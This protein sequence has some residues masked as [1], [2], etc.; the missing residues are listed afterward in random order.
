MLWVT[1]A[2]HLSPE[3]LVLI[4]VHTTWTITHSAKMYFSIFSRG[5]GKEIEWPIA[6]LTEKFVLKLLVSCQPLLGGGRAEAAG[7][8]SLMQE[9]SPSQ[10]GVQRQ[11]LH[12]YRCQPH[13]QRG[14][15][16]LALSAQTEVPSR[17]LSTDLCPNGLQHTSSIFRRR[18][19]RWAASPH[20]LCGSRRESPY[21]YFPRQRVP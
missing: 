15:R 16:L 21:P 14:N 7:E 13:R 1:S 8:L 19:K 18:W 17:A 12:G 4:Y 11:L 3:E 10:S 2:L 20:R 5:W 6:L 9:L